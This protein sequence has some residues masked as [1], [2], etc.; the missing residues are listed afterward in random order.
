MIN[1]ITLN[2]IFL[3][4]DRNYHYINHPLKY[5]INNLIKILNSRT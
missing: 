4:K 1:V 3:F 2:R 5:R